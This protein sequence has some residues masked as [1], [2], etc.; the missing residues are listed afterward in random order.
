MNKRIS[1]THKNFMMHKTQY[2]YYFL[3]V[4]NCIKMF[5]QPLN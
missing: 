2:F 1:K 4:Q 5:N 3:E